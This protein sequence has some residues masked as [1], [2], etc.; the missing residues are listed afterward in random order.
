[1]GFK[2]K[3]A[4]QAAFIG[5]K[6]DYLF[7]TIVSPAGTE[8]S[9]EDVSRATHISP[10]YLHRLRHKKIS[11][12]GRDVIQ[13]L[14]QFFGVPVEY[15]FS[16]TTYVS[17]DTQRQ[18]HLA[19]AHRTLDE[20]EY[21]PEQIR[22]IVQMLEHLRELTNAAPGPESPLEQHSDAQEGEE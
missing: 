12:P 7:R 8:Y 21:T 10:S 3:H 18:A 22:F 16:P 13:A 20:G 2:S 17:A 5:E 6:L 9:Y 19:I 14:S 15:W 4:E 11:N 1:M